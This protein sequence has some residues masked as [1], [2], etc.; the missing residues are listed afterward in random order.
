MKTMSSDFFFMD[1]SQA[2]RS[3]VCPRPQHSTQLKLGLPQKLKKGPQVDDT[4]SEVFSWFGLKM[5]LCLTTDP[6]TRFWSKPYALLTPPPNSG[7][8]TEITIRWKLGDRCPRG[9]KWVQKAHTDIANKWGNKLRH[10]GD[11]CAAGKVFAM[12]LQCSMISKVPTSR[13]TVAFGK[14]SRSPVFTDLSP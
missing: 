6:R 14:L 7:R 10:F 9:K 8:R 4:F 2:T 11:P 12:S 3:G 5:D 13:E 1:F